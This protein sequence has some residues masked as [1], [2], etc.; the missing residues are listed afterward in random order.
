MIQ[1]TTESVGNAI[2][3][4]A[5]TY[6]STPNPNAVNPNPDEEKKTNRTDGQSREHTANP[7]PSDTESV[8][9]MDPQNFKNSKEHYEALYGQ[10][11]T[12]IKTEKGLV[13][14]ITKRFSRSKKNNNKNKNNNNNDNQ[15]DDEQTESAPPPQAIP[16][17]KSSDKMEQEDDDD[18]DIVNEDTSRVQVNM[19]LNITLQADEEVEEQIEME[20]DDIDDDAQFQDAIEDEWEHND[21][22]DDDAH[23]YQDEHMTVDAYDFQLQTLDCKMSEF[24]SKLNDI[25]WYFDESNDG[26]FA[27]YDYTNDTFVTFDE[28]TGGYSWYHGT[29]NLA[30]VQIEEYVRVQ[31]E[32]DDDDQDYDAE[33]ENYVQPFVVKHFKIFPYISVCL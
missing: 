9:I 24:N 26:D 18:D 1:N 6:F 20:Q 13:S 23:Q 4:F 32:Q 21:N 14:K 15:T 27:G 31:R 16:T 7:S 8:E 17:T 25:S 12:K 22:D 19:D 33:H 5:N 30:R 3:N 11:N 10:K 2:S 28:E 29:S